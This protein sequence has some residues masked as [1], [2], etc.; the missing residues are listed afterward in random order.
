MAWTRSNHSLARLAIVLVMGV[1]LGV[2]AGC[3]TPRRATS[4]PAVEKTRRPTDKPN[5]RETPPADDAFDANLVPGRIHVVQRSDTLYSL[6]ER[7]Y[8]HGD[9]WKR[10]YSANGNRVK[11]PK[12]LPIGMRLIIP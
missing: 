2:A 1:V 4:Q 5:Q 10:I 3:A 12:K 11:D 8:G 7:Y 9:D 6:A